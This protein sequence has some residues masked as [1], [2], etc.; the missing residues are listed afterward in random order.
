MSVT[1]ESLLVHT[2]G[3]WFQ[4]SSRHQLTVANICDVLLDDVLSFAA[5]DATVHPRY[6]LFI[7]ALTDLVNYCSDIY[8]TDLSIEFMLQRHISSPESTRLNLTA[9]DANILISTYFPTLYEV[10]DLR[11]SD[12]LHLLRRAHEF[13]L[14]SLIP[15]QFMS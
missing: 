15:F 5:L 10:H 13:M 3:Q 12:G 14:T 11:D 8:R 4:F 7:A 2:V 1:V 6:N 9:V